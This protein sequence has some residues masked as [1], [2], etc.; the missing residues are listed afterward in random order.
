MNR[1]LSAVILAAGKGVRMKSDLP[2]VLHPVL[3]RPMVGH[4]IDA[5]RAVGADDVTLV[6]CSPKTTPAIHK[7]VVEQFT[8]RGERAIVS[9]VGRGGGQEETVASP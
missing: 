4:V 6:S 1:K 2:K 7:R 5:V 8:E 3:G 9:I